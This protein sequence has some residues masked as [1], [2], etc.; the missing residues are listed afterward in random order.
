MRS[1]FRREALLGGVG[2]VL[3]CCGLAGGQ[4]SQSNGVDVIER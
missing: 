4:I 2:M 3:T 1:V